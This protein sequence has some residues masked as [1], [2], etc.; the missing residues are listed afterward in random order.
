MT[1]RSKVNMLALAV[2]AGGAFSL[3]GPARAEAA[4]FDCN[5]YYAA[6]SDAITACAASGGT[7]ISISGWCSSTG[8]QLNS[9]CHYNES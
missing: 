6:R 4:A 1:F 8:H 7:R 9:T 2:V 5:D 3:A